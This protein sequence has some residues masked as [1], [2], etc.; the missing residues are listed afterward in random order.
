MK[1]HYDVQCRRRRRCHT[2][3]GFTLIELLVV[4]AILSLL[5]SILLPSLTRAR[6]LA[7]QIVCATNL[8]Q[9]GLATLMYSHDHED[10]LGNIARGPSFA[11]PFNF[12]TNH[13]SRGEY[14]PVTKWYNEPY[15]DTREEG[16]FRCPVAVDHI[17]WGGGYG[18]H[19]LYG[20]HSIHLGPS[21]FKSTQ[22]KNTKITEV[23]RPSEIL[24]FA[25]S[26]FGPSD[27]KAGK[28]SLLIYCPLC[29]DWN[30]TEASGFSDRHN[31]GGNV[32]FIEG[33]VEWRPFDEI[34]D[35]QGDIFGHLAP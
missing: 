8:K 34:Q 29:C 20:D 23:M 3:Y 19:C 9:I 16:V 18:A 5:V 2:W 11:V 14:L 15:G 21:L 4:I 27:P 7:K 6:E 28:T 33:H 26:A 22:F 17:A 35:N 25:D 30:L 24:M 10:Y 12:W 32:C 13:L 1:G 31:D